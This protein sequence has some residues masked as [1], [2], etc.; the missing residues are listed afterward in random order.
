MYRQ[1][2]CNSISPRDMVCVGNISVNT[3]HKE[4]NVI[5]NNN[6]KCDTVP[7]KVARIMLHDLLVIVATLKHID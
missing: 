6:N 3:L 7:V 2:S 4:E 5:N 1:I